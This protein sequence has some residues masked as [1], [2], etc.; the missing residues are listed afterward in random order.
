MI[1]RYEPL[2][3][4]PKVFLRVTGLRSKEFDTLVDEVLP[5]FMEAEGQRLAR[6]DRQRAIG[7]GEPPTLDER[8]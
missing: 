2:K 4:H 3:N 1:M 8:D 5:Q 7:A 6:P